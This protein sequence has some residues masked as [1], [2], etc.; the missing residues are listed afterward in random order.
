MKSFATHEGAEVGALWLGIS[1]FE[2]ADRAQ[3]QSM[4]SKPGSM[5]RAR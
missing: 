2:R 3:A 1:L 4:R 5:S